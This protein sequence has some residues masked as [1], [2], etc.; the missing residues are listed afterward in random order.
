M[1]IGEV[2]PVELLV[3]LVFV[4]LVFVAVAVVSAIVVRRR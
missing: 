4:L 3:M 1:G 2:G